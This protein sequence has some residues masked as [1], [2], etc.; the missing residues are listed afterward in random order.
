MLAPISNGR[1]NWAMTA[2]L[3]FAPDAAYRHSRQLKALIDEALDGL[4]MFLDVVYNHFGPSG[5]YPPT[6]GRYAPASSPIASDAGCVPALDDAGT[7]WP[8]AAATSSCTT[9]LLAAGNTVRRLA[10]RR[11]PR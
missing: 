1:R 4:M 11:R 2:L 7:R 6:L 9:R 8:P 10:A 3:L 5:N